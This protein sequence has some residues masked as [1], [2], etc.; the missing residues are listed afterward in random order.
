M[1]PSCVAACFCTAVALCACAPPAP[2]RSEAAPESA[3]P[4]RRP[5]Q[6]ADAQP[7]AGVTGPLAPH[8][9]KRS[10]PLS[11]EPRC[12][13]NDVTS[14]CTR[15]GTYQEDLPSL[16]ARVKCYY[17][18]G[19]FYGAASALR[20]WQGGGGLFVQRPDGN[21][22]YRKDEVSELYALAAYRFAIQN[23]DRPGGEGAS[24]AEREFCSAVKARPDVVLPLV[25]KEGLD[26]EARPIFE[27]AKARCLVPGGWVYP[28]RPQFYFQ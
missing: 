20:E 27:R 22:V 28:S 12:F 16:L 9:A 8:A 5:V 13:P 17:E 19:S 7:A 10:C 24:K 11:P 23:V 21:W 26:T 3:P 25:E 15:R 1:R 14:V 2:P 4:A 6:P 18:Q